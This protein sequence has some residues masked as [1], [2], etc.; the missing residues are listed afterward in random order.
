MPEL[1]TLLSAPH[2]FG[3]ET[4]FDHVPSRLS[5]RLMPFNLQSTFEA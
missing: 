5:L 3:V 1:V 4:V 2:P